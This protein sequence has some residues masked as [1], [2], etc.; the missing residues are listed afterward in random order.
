MK[1]DQKSGFFTDTIGGHV[2]IDLLNTVSMVGGHPADSLQSDEDVLDWLAEKA[3][4]TAPKNFEFRAGELL[5]T[6]RELREIIRELITARKEKRA[7]ELHPINAFLENGS[8]YLQV[9]HANGILEITRQ[10]SI[11]TTKQLLAP[12]AE[13]AAEILTANNFDLIRKCESAECLIWFYDRTKGHKRRWCS[14]AIC[15]NRHKVSSFRKR[16]SQSAA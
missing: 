1:T 9:Q 8:S 11:T 7:L 2:A 4:V 16:Q 12:L 13:A 10:R 6:A 15:G 14:M 3:I 5:K